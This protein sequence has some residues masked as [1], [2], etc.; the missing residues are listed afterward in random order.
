MLFNRHIN[1]MK[2]L[3]LYENFNDIDVVNYILT[4]CANIE[5]KWYFS[6]RKLQILTKKFKNQRFIYYLDQVLA[7]NITDKY[8]IQ[9]YICEQNELNYLILKKNLKD[10]D[11]R[12]KEKYN[13]LDSAEDLGLF[14]KESLNNDLGF[15]KELY[16]YGLELTEIEP[17]WLNKMNNLTYLN[18]HNNQLT[19]LPELPKTLTYLYCS[20]NELTKLPE[21]PKTLNRLNCSDNPGYE[22][23]KKEPKYKKFNI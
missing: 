3:K 23:W 14:Y 6:N 4:E 13:D 15:I 10:I 16:I 7:N 21:L 9:K 17:G 20:E 19:D 22:K 5:Y 12:I 8:E 11:D 1:Y 18:C 2:H